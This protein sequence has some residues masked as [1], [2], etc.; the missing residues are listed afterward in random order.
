MMLEELE[1]ELGREEMFK[2]KT[3]R[4]APRAYE[5]TE[6][7]WKKI[8]DIGVACR[9]F[10]KGIDRLYYLSKRGK[11]LLRNKDLRAE[12]VLDYWERG[13]PEGLIEHGGLKRLEGEIPMLMRPDLLVTEEGFALTELD[14]VPGGYGLTGY[15]GE[16]YGLEEMTGKFYEALRK[17]YK[18]NGEPVIVIV[19]SDEA[20]TYRPEH[21][22]LARRLRE[23]GKLIYCAHPD[24]ITKGTE[25][26]YYEG[27]RVDV[28]YR[29]FELFDLANV[30]CAEDLMEAEVEGKVVVTPPMK[31]YH[32]EKL[33][34]GLFHHYEL[35]GY[36]REQ[37]SEGSYELL[38]EIIPRTWIM[39]PQPVGANA[40]L[41]GPKLGMKTWEALGEMSQRERE[42]VIKISGF[43]ERAWGSRGVHIG[44]DC[45]KEQWIKA[46]KQAVDEGGEKLYVLM[47]Y[48]KPVVHKYE[49]YGKNGAV[50]EELGRVR[51]CPYYLNNGNEVITAGVLATIC[52]AD[53]KIIHGMGDA[54]LVPCRS[55]T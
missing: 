38:K 12:W 39:D 2:G 10:Y 13:K 49:Y 18:G 46:I 37:L 24:E 15:M 33:N 50:T 44:V 20:E 6:E 3:W 47:D 35:E 17:M 21:E 29:M 55:R 14:S 27:K 34:L 31:S 51:L 4:V 40:M 28:V 11:K 54:V 9:D 26:V 42:Y 19:V 53:K 45:S 7:Q 5:L 1:A 32:E 41:N 52:P 25:G 23:E 48:A 36:W 43:D 30:S 16:V 8:G 22:W